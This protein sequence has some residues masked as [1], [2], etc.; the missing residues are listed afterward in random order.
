MPS[1]NSSRMVQVDAVRHGRLEPHAEH[2]SVHYRILLANHLRQIE[3]GQA[4]KYCP[5]ELYGNSYNSIFPAQILGQVW[6][7]WLFWWA[8]LPPERQRH[9]AQMIRQQYQ[10]LLF[11]SPDVLEPGFQWWTA[12]SACLILVPGQ[13]CTCILHRKNAAKSVS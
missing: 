10:V 2:G 11:E 9:L 13:L 3:A 8:F 12:S 5:H 1:A 7:A 6:S 4:G